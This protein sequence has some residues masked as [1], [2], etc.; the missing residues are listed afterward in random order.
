M[1]AILKFSALT[2]FSG[3]IIFL[4]YSTTKNVDTVL[5]ETSKTRMLA[6]VHLAQF[7]TEHAKNE[8]TVIDVRTAAEFNDGHINGSKNI[9]FYST[10]FTN[11]LNEL[12]KNAP[13]LIYCR[14]GNRSKQ[15]LYIMESLGFTDVLDLAGGVI[16]WEENDNILCTNC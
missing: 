1:N 13:Y 5:M 14:S 16:A 7:K 10:S 15:A 12:D 8:R 4:L 9:D 2:V 11:E 6:T 3:L